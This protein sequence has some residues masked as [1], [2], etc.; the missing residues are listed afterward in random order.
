MRT[1]DDDGRRGANIEMAE[2]SNGVGL[3]EMFQHWTLY[4]LSL[5]LDI[6]LTKS[7]VTGRLIDPEP[8]LVAELV[9]VV[10]S[11][12]RYMRRSSEAS[13]CQEGL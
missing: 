6:F 1:T 10:D 4:R 7:F 3:T 11:V 5:V 13:C 12:N 8:L 9:L 2:R